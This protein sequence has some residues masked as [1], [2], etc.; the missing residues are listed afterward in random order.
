MESRPGKEAKVEMEARL[1]ALETTA[2]DDAPPASAV[3]RS[4]S[5]GGSN[6]NDDDDDDEPPPEIFDWSPFVYRA[7]F[8]YNKISKA[9]VDTAELVARISVNSFRAQIIG[10]RLFVKDIRALEFARD[11]APSWKITL[12]ETMRRRRDLPDIDAVFNEGDYPIVLLPNDG[13]HAQRLYGREGMSN[14]Q[15]PPPLFSPTTNVHMTRD[16]PFPDFSF[17][18]PGVKGADRLSTTRWSVAHGRLL[19]AGAK[20]PFEDKIPLAA[21][22]GNTQAEPRQR[23]AE[24]ARSNPDSVFVNQVFKKSPTGERSCV[25]LG[26][27]DKGGLQADKCALSFEEM[28]RYRYLVNVGSNGYANKLKSLF[29]CGSVVI[30][31]ESSAPNKEFFEHQLLPGVHYVSVRDSSDVP[32]WFERWRKIRAG[33]NPSPPRARGAWQPLTPTPCTITSRRR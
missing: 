4:E 12:L 29:L 24:V 30:N 11:Y 2:T 3:N 33:R 32:G 7:M 19:E 9:D 18:P 10:G 31:V 27:A 23:L 15:K 25:Q 13:A 8:P 20:I 6:N 22:T 1:K 16:V 28:C 17:S 26:L 5:T 14:G 21:F